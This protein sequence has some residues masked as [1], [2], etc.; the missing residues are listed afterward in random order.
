MR[1]FDEVTVQLP[2]REQTIRPARHERA[3]P[4][5]PVPSYLDH[6]AD[7]SGYAGCPVANS[8][9]GTQ[10]EASTSMMCV[11]FSSDSIVTAP[12]AGKRQ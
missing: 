3:T 9:A 5:D 1:R 4:I 7:S 12:S 8:A 6:R 10:L 11:D 2:V